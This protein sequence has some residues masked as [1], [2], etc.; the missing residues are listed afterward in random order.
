MQFGEAVRIGSKYDRREFIAGHVP[1]EVFQIVSP[2]FGSGAV[3]LELIRQ[4]RNLRV[5]GFD[6]DKALVN[7]WQELQRSPSDLVSHLET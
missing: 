4:R 5:V 6:G 3:E 7:F 2:F 1:R